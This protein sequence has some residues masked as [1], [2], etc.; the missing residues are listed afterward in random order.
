[1]NESILFLGRENCIYTKKIHILLKKKFKKIIFLKSKKIGEKLNENDKIF[2]KKFDYIFCFRS[3]YILNKLLKKVN[4]YA[5]NFHPSVPKYRGSGGVNYAVFNDKHFGCTAH[6]INNKIDSGNII[7]VQF[8]NHG[9]MKNLKTILNF[10]YSLQLKQIKKIIN[11]IQKDNLFINNQIKKNI[12]IKW[13]KTLNTMKDL[14]KFYKIDKKISKK[15]FNRKLKATIINNHKPYLI[16]RGKK[17]I[18]D[19]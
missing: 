19:N 3:F 10:T 16:L 6:L 15:D 2:R 5:I 11:G 13:G 8:F 14:N 7:D 9:K 17:F 12:N 18:L 1:M 4:K